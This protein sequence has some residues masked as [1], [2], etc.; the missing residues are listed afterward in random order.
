MDNVR[1]G[2]DVCQAA[3]CH[4]SKTGCS[5]RIVFMHIVANIQM[6]I[7]GTKKERRGNNYA[8]YCVNLIE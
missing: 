7:A 1:R 2:I 8:T 3:K 5:V 4:V 6:K